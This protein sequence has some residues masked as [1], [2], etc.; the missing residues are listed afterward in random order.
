[1]SEPA[2]RRLFV[3]TANSGKVAEFQRIFGGSPIEI[4]TPPDQ[5]HETVVAETGETFA[6]N[7]RLKARAGSGMFGGWTLADDSGLEVDALGGEPGLRSSRY[8]GRDASD[9]DRIALLL[10]RLTAARPAVRTARFRCALVIAAPDG[11]IV[12]ETEGRCEGRIAARARGTHGFG[13]DPIFLVGDGQRTM[14]ELAP[15]EKDRLS[16]R[17]QAARAAREFLIRGNA[18]E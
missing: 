5:W 17:G 10:R 1:M 12:F 18:P 13:Y 2:V 8:A 11:S 3:A 7:A 16:H 15:A 6:E 9:D 14:A 4:A